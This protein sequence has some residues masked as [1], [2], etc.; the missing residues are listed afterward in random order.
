M[1]FFSVFTLPYLAV[2]KWKRRKWNNSGGH[3]DK[4]DGEREIKKTV[5]DFEMSNCVISDIINCNGENPRNRRYNQSSIL[6][7][8]GL[9]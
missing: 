8:L 7:M 1:Q 6:N 3:T 2:M 5:Y 4:L 9:K